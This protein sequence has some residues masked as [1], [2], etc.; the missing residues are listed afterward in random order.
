MPPQTRHR[1]RSSVDH[2]FDL[3]EDLGDEQLQDLLIELDST[4]AHVPVSK[5]V[6]FFD[7]RRR[8]TMAAGQ[9]QLRPTPSFLN[10]PH[11]PVDWPRQKPRPVSGMPH[12]W[13]QSMRIVSTPYGNIARHQTEPI[14]PPLTASPPSSP[15]LS[16]MGSPGSPKRS[17]TAPV[18]MKGG[19]AM[20]VQPGDEVRVLAAGSPESPVSPPRHHLDVAGEDEA[21]RPSLSE[22][23]SFSFRFDGARPEAQTHTRQEAEEEEETHNERERPVSPGAQGTTPPPERVATDFSRINTMPLPTRTSLDDT[24]RDLPRPSTSMGHDAAK[25]G[26]RAFR[27]I[28]RPLFLSPAG[29]PGADDLAKKLSAYLF[30]NLPLPS[31]PPTAAAAPADRE[32]KLSIEDLL[33]EPCAPPRSRFAFGKVEREAPGVSGIFEVLTEG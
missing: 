27:R 33:K 16:A 10:A 12:P 3:V 21:S 29:G 11:E 20:G 17:V 7:E 31:S 24:L 14:S 32:R 26:P 30:D 23:G 22:F 5:G 4:G 28:S 18:L 15:P 8:R 9:H 2:I 13:R 19:A 1:S 6:E 25:Q